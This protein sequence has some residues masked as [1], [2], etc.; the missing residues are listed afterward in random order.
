MASSRRL[1]FLAALGGVA[2][3]DW[4]DPKTPQD[5]RRFTVPG[6]TK[7]LKA[8][9]TDEFEE[10]WLS[11]RTIDPSNTSLSPKWTATYHLD[12][13]SYGATFMHPSM[14]SAAEGKLNIEAHKQ[15]FAG[16]DFLA[17]QLSSW[18][19]FCF[20]GGYLEVNYK[21]PG[22][23]RER[24]SGVWPAIWVMGNLARDVYTSSV[25][26]IW[27]F[28]YDDC[29]C[30]GQQVKYGTRQ[31]ISKCDAR[32]SRYGMNP[33][34]G[35]GAVELD[36]L[37]TT[38]CELQMTPDLEAR[39]V[40]KNDTCLI[41]SLQLAPRIPASYR[42]ILTVMPDPPGTPSGREWYGAMD[43]DNGASL[44]SAFYGL[45]NYDTIGAIS[46]LPDSAYS[47]Y[48]SIALYTHIGPTCAM[49][50]WHHVEP[51]NATAAAQCRHDSYL[52][53]YLDGKM[54]TRINGS[55]FNAYGD[56]LAREF[57]QEPTYIMLEVKLAPDR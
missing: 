42:P 4:V 46:T 1:A 2:G 50:I 17:G 35:R 14:I 6:T 7:Q 11:N 54:L 43:F 40:L 16:A 31:R 49:N 25:E 27:P 56:T 12:T 30:P 21:L 3:T 38:L 52:E 44:N 51:Q 29:S 24:A 36:L 10:V 55:A 26:S 53:W 13:D 9:F 28:T 34:Q 32:T 37:E 22:K 8:V 39:G 48:S 41:N 57:P 5:K 45:Y 15:K 20:Q 33:N 47:E 19:N 23:P 18:N